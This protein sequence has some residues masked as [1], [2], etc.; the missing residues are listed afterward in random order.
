MGCIVSRL[1][2]IFIYFLYLQGPLLIYCCKRM[3]RDEGATG[4]ILVSVGGGATLCQ[5]G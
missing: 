5:Q 1:F 4:G 2:V 3:C